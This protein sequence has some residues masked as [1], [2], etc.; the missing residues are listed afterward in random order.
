MT[1]IDDA[2]IDIAVADRPLTEPELAALGNA[3]SFMERGAF[4]T[5]RRSPSFALELLAGGAVALLVVGLILALLRPLQSRP[6][7]IGSRPTASPT[8]TPGPSA[9]PTQTTLPLDIIAQLNLGSHYVNAMAVS[10]DAVWLAVQGVNY[11][12]AGTLIR[13]NP[14][15]ARKTASWTIGGDPAAV[16]AAGNFV[17]VANGVGDGSEVLPEQNTV[18]QFNATTGALVHL[19]RV[20]DPRGLVANVGSALVVSASTP[21]QTAISLL[22]G[23]SSQAIASPSG[24]LEATSTSPQSGIAVCGHKAYVALT[25]SLPTGANVTFYSVAPTGGAVRTIAMVPSEFAPAMVCDATSLYLPAPFGKAGQGSLL[26]VS[27][28]TGAVTTLWQGPA[29]QAL[30]VAAG[31]LWF[32]SFADIPNDESVFLSSIDPLTG[33]ASSAR[34]FLPAGPNRGD[35]D[36]L[37]P[38]ATGL[39]TVAGGGNLL[40]HIAVG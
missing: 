7:A 32:T 27:A 12:D 23:G 10:P 24:T 16:A 6:L 25:N 22:I 33:L 39:W 21:E 20:H 8:A 11:G 38:G 5:S 17:W 30:A 19:Y 26:R 9:S 2:D 4:A 34:Q 40:L 37:V 35:P 29:P 28:S 13:V 14:K 3:R 1:Y 15:T 36:L 31:R 18:E